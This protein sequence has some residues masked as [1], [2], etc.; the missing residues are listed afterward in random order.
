MEFVTHPVI[1][2][3]NTQMTSFPSYWLCSHHV[4]TAELGNFIFKKQPLLP[5]VKVDTFT[6]EYYRK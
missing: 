6:A 4:A 5:I 1:S 3:A 2:A